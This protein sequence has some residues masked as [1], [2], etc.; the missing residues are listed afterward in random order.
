[1][2]SFKQKWIEMGQCQAVKW[3][4]TALHRQGLGK[5]FIEKKQSKKIVD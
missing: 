4:L 2:F 1:M 3:F 5:I